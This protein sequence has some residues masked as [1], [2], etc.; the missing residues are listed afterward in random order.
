MLNKKDY[1]I[2][3]STKISVVI[4][5]LQKNEMKII[6]IL[7]AKQKLI[8][9]ITDGDIRRGLINGYQ[10]TDDC[11]SIMNKKPIYVY[12]SDHKAIKRKFNIKNIS[13]P[14][15]RYMLI[16]DQNNKF[17][18]IID[19]AD[20]S[21]ETFDNSVIIM[22]GGEGKRLLPHTASTPKPMLLLNNKPIIRIIIDRLIN[23]GFKNI[24][25]SIRYEAE[26]LVKY[27][28]KEN[29]IKAN[30]SFILESKPLGTAGCLALMNKRQCDKPII[31]TNG[32]VLTKVNY[33][34]LLKYHINSKNIITVCASEYT[35]SLPYGELILKNNKLSEIKEKP[36]SKHLIN[37]GIYIIDPIVLKNMKKNERIDM[38]ELL[39]FYIKSK[40][41]GIYP[42][43]ESWIDIGNPDD[44][45]KAK[46]HL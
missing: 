12:S 32:D 29:G 11:L 45:D 20:E 23:H 36:I 35:V 4:K 39:D 40:S 26:K 27:F 46:N 8:G 37:A 33:S 16:V 7:D 24:N 21:N 3:K 25:I 5:M 30:V 22:A 1:I 41:V 13:H 19:R 15:K 38:T 42:L 9:T 31:L 43:H 34:Q 44:Y 17:I 14:E 28:E 6:V 18:E 10:I 2:N